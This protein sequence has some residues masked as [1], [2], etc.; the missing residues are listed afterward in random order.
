M[1]NKVDDGTIILELDDPI[2]LSSSGE[3][4][5]I[6]FNSVSK[7][8]S[9][10]KV[11]SSVSNTLNTRNLEINYRIALSDKPNEWTEWE[12][13]PNIGESNCFVE[14]SSFYDYN[15]QIKFI[16]T[17]S[18]NDG[19]L[20]V[21]N[22]RWEGKWDVNKIESAYVDLTPGIS[23]IIVDV[24]NVYKV[25]ELTGFELVARNTQDLSLKYR[26]SQDSKRTWTEWT[27]LTDANIKTERIDDIRF[28]NI[29]Y[30]LEHTGDSGTIIIRDINLHGDFI[31]VTN[32]YKTS[33]LI[34]IRENCKN[35][36]I[37]NTC[38]YGGT[39]SNTID[40]SNN[41]E[42][43]TETNWSTI[44]S[45]DSEL[46]NIYDLGGAIN[47]FEKLSD[48]ATKIGGWSVEYFK[49]SP[50][51]NGIDH[52]IHEYSLYNIIKS[53]DVKI[54]VPDN[55]FPNNQMAFNQFDL[56]LLE[57]FE[58]HLTKE[59]FKRVFG[60][61]FRPSKE[62]F[63]YFCEISKMFR[64]QNSQA[65]R[66]FGNASVYYKLILS[67]YNE[68][69]NVKSDEGSAI[70][71][72][73]D[74]ILK[75]STL[76]DL[77]STEKKE[78]QEKVAF[79]KQHD[80][81]TNDQI[82]SDI[83]ATIEKE[84]LDNAELVLSKYQYN[85]MGIS[86][87]NDAVVYQKSDLYLR[88]GDNRSFVAW[89]KLSDY[90]DSD[91]YNLLENYS[92]DLGKGYRFD[93]KDNKISTKVNNSIY[94]TDLNDILVDDIWY[95]IVINIDQRQRKLTHYLYKRNVDREIDAKNLLSTKLR[96]L[97][98]EDFDHSPK[99]FEMEEKDVDMKILG[100]NMK[101]TNLRIFNDVIEDSESTK[102]LNQQIIRDTDK[103]LL[104]DN[105]NKIFVLPRFPYLGD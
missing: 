66:D 62:D 63:L 86:P 17:G 101:I 68:R 7:L 74:D 69:A 96:L 94:E 33:N 84:L 19:E 1:V 90:A 48:D 92:N 89:F 72:R 29:Q 5:I 58:V 24:P 30:K 95:C 46:L 105:C 23:P 14:L 91:V 103:A 10:N 79:K 80:T 36:M 40:F 12:E 49:T 65:I 50:D 76:E 70:Q 39:G 88:E 2:T 4:K 100:S 64:V 81:L 32:N 54:L 37:G 34:G 56:S 26:I 35:G 45:D 6:S 51:S 47:L 25:F 97:I 60:A 28:F 3:E 15:I 52:T 9:L 11:F 21:E 77:F 27:Y 61:E 22:F 98:K 53:G 93:I 16:R 85:L 87:D 71:E 43:N 102:I 41:L 31:D 82:R 75:N 99:K 20:I 55:Q 59:E 44:A 42:S 18:N 78:D 8:I 104:V 73:V 38:L 83:Y 13:I 57:S 67:K